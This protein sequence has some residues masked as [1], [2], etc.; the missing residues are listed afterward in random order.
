MPLLWVF[1]DQLSPDL[2]TLVAAPH[3]PALL[4]ESAVAFTMLPYHPKRLTFLVS[5]MRHFAAE[6]AKGHRDIHYYPL[7]ENGYL[8]SLS[9][10]RDV[11]AKTGEREVWVVEPSEYHTRAWLETLPERLGL[12]I[13]YFPNTLFLTDR[14]EFRSWA[15][16]VTSP[17]M[18]VFY[19]RMRTRHDVLMD[20][21]DPAGGRWNL[22]QDNRKPLKKSIDIPRMMTFEP[23][24]I[25]KDVMA[26]VSRRF[27]GTAGSV[28]GFAMPVTRSQAKSAFEHFL[29]HRL[30]AFGDY[31]DAMVT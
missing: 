5:A 24:A 22:D 21:P 18:E 7:C 27:G 12:T 8:D 4:I 9:A 14:A 3:A 25:T 28:D 20:G 16:G 30:C 19:R 13:R 10:L 11:V 1:E 31:E 15:R 2:P 29:D 17:V 23:D 26:E 6:L